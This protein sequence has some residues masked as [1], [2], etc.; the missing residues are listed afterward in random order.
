MFFPFP[1]TSEFVMYIINNFPLY[2]V[3]RYCRSV[4]LNNAL[5]TPFGKDVKGKLLSFKAYL[6]FLVLSIWLTG[7]Q[8][9]KSPSKL[10]QQ[11]AQKI[12]LDLRYYCPEMTPK[13]RLDEPYPCK[14]PLTKLPKELSKL[15]EESSL[16]AV[17]LFSENLVDSE[18]IIQLTSDLSNAAL[19]SQLAQPLLISIDQEGGRVARLP[20]AMATTFT[21]NMSIGATHTV[22]GDKYASAVG[23]VLGNE[24]SALGI[25]VNHAPT[26]DVNINPN[27]PVINVR[28]FSDDPKLVGELG[29]AMLKGI[30]SEGVIGTLKHFPGHG[31][32]NVDSHTGLPVVNHDLKTI[33]NVDLLP[34][35]T[36]IDQGVVDMIMTAHIQ[37]PAL[38]SSE[39]INKFGQTML[40]PATLSYAILTDLLRNDMK[41]QGVIVSDA[42]DMAGISHF[43]TPIEAVLETF[44]AGTD[45]AMM[46]MRIR[47]PDDIKQFKK[48]LTSLANRV[49]EQTT[50]Y[51]QLHASLNRIANLKTKLPRHILSKKDIVMK[52]Q[53]AKTILAH[54]N[55][56]QLEQAL[57][58]SA[59]VEIKK[60][61]DHLFIKNKVKK[62][63]IIFPKDIQS[64]AMKYSLET[65]FKS[66]SEK[67]WQFTLSYLEN[68]EDKDYLNNINNSDLVIVA[69]ESQKTA[70]DMGGVEDLVTEKAEAFTLAD[71]ALNVLKYAKSQHKKTIFVTLNI[72]YQLNTF[73]PFSD[74]ILTS[75]DGTAYIDSSTGEF[76]S[77]TFD[78]LASV[79][80]GNSK[81]E[82]TLPIRL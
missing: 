36:A 22:Y 45:I 30:Q 38:D 40:K 58:K 10:E 39:L 3:T 68:T 64:K 20:K 26:V 14:T 2:F 60:E 57:A 41:Y 27:N 47:M 37:Y 25:N 48:F 49:T 21:G 79:I 63:H 44:N 67:K 29:I 73:A 16:G 34:F 56:R 9:E 1:Q 74:W 70:V 15:I 77:P 33:K 5:I 17:I 61:I 51:Q 66:L 11:L 31:D 76:K 71:K 7:C 8:V 75:F 82:G 81:V 23:K 72:P 54:T 12:M 59:V 4:N 46:P 6:L 43:F 55:S 18:Q 65:Q 78:A 19:K 42:L 24:L 32:T 50:A 80:S 62:I 52:Q 35:Q 53:A 69:S 28:A 13:D